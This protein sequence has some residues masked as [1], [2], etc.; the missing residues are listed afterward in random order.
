MLEK[1]EIAGTHA[2]NFLEALFKAQKSLLGR[3]Q[4]NYQKSLDFLEK[5][6]EELLQNL[7]E[8]CKPVE[9]RPLSCFSAT[10]NPSLNLMKADSIKVPPTVRNQKVVEVFRCFDRYDDSL[11]FEEI[12]D[13][14]KK[15]EGLAAQTP[16]QYDSYMSEV[17][18][19]V[20]ER[21]KKI[22]SV[23]YG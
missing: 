15:L 23:R 8:Q 21:L 10:M 6:M 20:E 9:Q 16:E 13:G 22:N 2:E 18:E 4:D 14:V 1:Y 17:K 3:D 5:F 11:T 12:A 19:A 7:K